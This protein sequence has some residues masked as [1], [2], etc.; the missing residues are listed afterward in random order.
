MVKGPRNHEPHMREEAVS[1]HH[2][3]S[4][5]TTASAIAPT[6]VVGVA[7]LDSID[8]VDGIVVSNHGGRQVDGAIASLDA[9]VAKLRDSEQLDLDVYWIPTTEAE[10][11]AALTGFAGILLIGYLGRR[12]FGDPA[13][14]FAA[15]VA[16]SSLYYVALGH[17]ST[18]DMGLTFFMTAAVGGFLLAQKGGPLAPAVV[19]YPP[20]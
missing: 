14:W 9:L 5:S 15:A 19:K 4:F 20:A 1:N 11:P 12:L 3:L 8:G 7:E 17:I 6:T 13:G 2:V 18:L 10:D 16:A